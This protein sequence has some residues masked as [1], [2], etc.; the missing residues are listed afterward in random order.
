MT[1]M[2]KQ[3]FLSATMLAIA[4]FGAAAQAQIDNAIS[5]IEKS[6][7]VANAIYSENRD[8]DTHKLVK[9]SKMLVING[10]DAAAVIR[11]IERERE[12]SVS[13]EQVGH[14]IYTVK[15]STGKM[16]ST[17]T[18]LRQRNGTWMLTV[19]QRPAGNAS[20]GKKDRVV[21]TKKGRVVL[22]NF[23]DEDFE[24]NIDI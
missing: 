15:F 24:I 4:A 5:K 16:R 2:I 6:N 14:G 9:S 22:N 8:P 1:M 12:K 20:G 10:D 11:A 3:L 18:L 13:Y 17:Y 21:K 19:E 7:R 23:F